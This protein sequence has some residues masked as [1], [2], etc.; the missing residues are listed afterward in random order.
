M[1]HLLSAI[2]RYFEMLR[3]MLTS[4][5][6]NYLPAVLHHT[7]P[8]F[9]DAH[10]PPANHEVAVKVVATL[11]S[12]LGRSNWRAFQCFVDDCALAL[13]GACVRALCASVCSLRA[14]FARRFEV[15]SQTFCLFACGAVVARQ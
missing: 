3:P 12:L 7:I 11:L 8:M 14:F 5:E 9:A 1:R 13:S 15:R 6:S 10:A 4:G 2:D